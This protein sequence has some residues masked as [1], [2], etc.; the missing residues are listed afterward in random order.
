MLREL[1]V[2]AVDNIKAYYRVKK[3]LDTMKEKA[4][5]LPEQKMREIVVASSERKEAMY[6]KKV[7]RYLAFEEQI[8]KA[9][10]A[11]LQAK[12]GY[13][14]QVI[15]AVIQSIATDQYVPCRGMTMRDMAKTEAAFIKT[16]AIHIFGKTFLEESARIDASL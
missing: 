4:A 15:V 9:F 14:K 10:P 12:R 3:M 16:V 5:S 6:E 2:L 1:Y 7:I 11:V 13:K 8:E